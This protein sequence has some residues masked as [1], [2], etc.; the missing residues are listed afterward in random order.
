MLKY[1]NN[2]NVHIYTEKTHR[3]YPAIHILQKCNIMSPTLCIILA[4]IIY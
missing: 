3:D 2:G 1:P 4:H